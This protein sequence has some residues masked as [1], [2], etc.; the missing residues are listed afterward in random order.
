M[1]IVTVTWSDCK[2]LA[3]SASQAHD[4]RVTG[5]KLQRPRLH[6]PGSM[7]SPLRQR[8]WSL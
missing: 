6:C 3:N 4:D 1:F 8:S 7:D 5:E 2:Q